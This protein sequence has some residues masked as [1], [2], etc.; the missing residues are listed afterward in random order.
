MDFCLFE[1][2]KIAIHISKFENVSIIDPTWNKEGNYFKMMDFPP[3]SK[4]KLLYM[5][6]FFF[7]IEM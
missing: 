3:N 2:I 1:V 4:S 6:I 7:K 5:Y